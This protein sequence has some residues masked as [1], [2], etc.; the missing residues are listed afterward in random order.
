MLDAALGGA[1]PAGRNADQLHR[2]LR[3]PRVTRRWRAR[4][5]RSAA[6][7]QERRSGLLGNESRR[8]DARAAKHAPLIAIPAGVLM[9]RFSLFAFLFFLSALAVAQRVTLVDRIVAVVNKEVIT[10]SELNQAV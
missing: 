2:F 5:G 10:Y 8:P 6:T 7:S 4:H 9:I 3:I 1:A